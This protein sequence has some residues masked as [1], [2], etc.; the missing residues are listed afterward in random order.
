MVIPMNDLVNE[1]IE[2]FFEKTIQQ[3]Q[4][5]DNIDKYLANTR[6][7]TKFKITDSTTRY[8]KETDED[9]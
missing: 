3:K 1:V 7:K 2:Q 4:G 6:R 9:G 5:C 8:K